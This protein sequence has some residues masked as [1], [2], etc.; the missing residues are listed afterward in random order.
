MASY[1]HQIRATTSSH[2]AYTYIQTHNFTLQSG[3]TTK[4]LWM[5]WVLNTIQVVQFLEISTRRLDGWSCVGHIMHHWPREMC[6]STTS[7]F[8]HKILK[9]SLIQRLIIQACTWI[10]THLNPCVGPNGRMHKPMHAAQRAHVLVYGPIGWPR[11]CVHVWLHSQNRSW[12]IINAISKHNNPL[13]IWGGNSPMS[14]LRDDKQHDSSL[15]RGLLGHDPSPSIRWLLHNCPTNSPL[16]HELLNLRPPPCL[17]HQQQLPTTW[18]KWP[19]CPPRTTVGNITHF[20]ARIG[21]SF[22]L[23]IKS[24]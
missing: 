21:S 8:S 7:S 11:G 10:S 23:S 6:I 15:T 9:K 20:L 4:F 18:P 3:K 1:L 19:S 24:S 17:Y 14:G 16:F 13:T 22:R 2:A 12:V 5:W